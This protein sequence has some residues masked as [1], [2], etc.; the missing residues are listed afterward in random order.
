MGVLE[1]VVNDVIEMLEGE[2]LYLQKPMC[3]S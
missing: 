2:I 1:G 3:R